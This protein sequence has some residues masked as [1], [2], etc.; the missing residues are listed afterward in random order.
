[1]W[2]N[3]YDSCDGQLARMTGKKTLWGR[4]LD[5]FAGDIW[6][7]T[8][9]IAIVARLWN[10]NIPFTNFHWGWWSWTPC[11]YNVYLLIEVILSQNKTALITSCALIAV[12]LLADILILFGCQGIVL[13]PY[14]LLVLTGMIVLLVCEDNSFLKKMNI[15]TLVMILAGA[16]SARL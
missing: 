4:M 15:F 11:F 12:D 5:G 16:F 3:F 6:F 8:I 2:A 13:W 7:F 9:Y 1:M 14:M 10:Q